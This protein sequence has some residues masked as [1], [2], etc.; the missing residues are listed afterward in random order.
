MPVAVPGVVLALALLAGGAALSATV[1][2]RDVRRPLEAHVDIDAVDGPPVVVLAEIRS[3]ATD[4]ARDVA[5]EIRRGLAASRR[6]GAVLYVNQVEVT[7]EDVRVSVVDKRGRARDAGAPLHTLAIAVRRGIAGVLDTP[8]PRLY[9]LDNLVDAAFERSLGRIVLV[10]FDAR[11]IQRSGTVG[12]SAASAVALPGADG[13]ELTA[14]TITTASGHRLRAAEGIL[15]ADGIVFVT[16]GYRHEP[17]GRAQPVSGAF[18]VTA[19]GTT[20]VRRGP[21]PINVVTAIQPYA[22]DDSR[23]RFPAV[24]PISLVFIGST[25]RSR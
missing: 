12:V 6:D 8:G 18:T 17:A 22:G 1:T 20:L 3:W 24:D 15:D 23:E 7:L 5:L 16:S 25:T 13:I 10:P 19:D 4:D 14:L 2:S 9:R 21:V 11:V